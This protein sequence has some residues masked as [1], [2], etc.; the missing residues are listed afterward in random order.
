MM[1]VVC[2]LRGTL[3][4]RPGSRV[5]SVQRR[6]SVMVEI[7]PRGEGGT[8]FGQSPLN[9]AQGLPRV[10]TPCN[11]KQLIPGSGFQ[12]G[13]QSSPVTSGQGGRLTSL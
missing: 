1:S 2:P 13:R 10:T 7:R 8:A 12:S 3:R 4:F 6:D 11:Q 5:H 9:P